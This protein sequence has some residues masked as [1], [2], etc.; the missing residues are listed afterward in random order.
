[1]GERT[2]S[3]VFQWVWSYVVDLAMKLFIT[4]RRCDLDELQTRSKHVHQRQGFDGDYRCIA[5]I[6]NC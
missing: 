5:Y 3:R 2:G 1:M 4:A 6:F